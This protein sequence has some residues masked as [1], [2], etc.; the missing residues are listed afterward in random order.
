MHA[1]PWVNRQMDNR[2]EFAKVCG[3]WNFGMD[4]SSVGVCVCS[5]GARCVVVD[6][7]GL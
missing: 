3:R 4:S 7:S 2:G 6:G 1:M 5:H